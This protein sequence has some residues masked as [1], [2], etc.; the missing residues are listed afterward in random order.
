MAPLREMPQP[1][2][3]L[4]RAARPL[5][6]NADRCPDLTSDPDVTSGPEVAP[7]ADMPLDTDL[8]VSEDRYFEAGGRTVALTG[9]VL[10]YLPDLPTSAALVH[11]ID[12]SALVAD[13]LA[14]LVAVERAL[15]DLGITRSRLRLDAPPPQLA[16]ALSLLD[17]RAERGNGLIR[18]AAPLGTDVTLIQIRDAADWERKLELH[19]AV[20]REGAGE[21][22]AMVVAVERLK[23]EAGHLTLWLA[24]RDGVPAA[25]V[26]SAQVGSLLR[27]RDLTVAPTPRRRGVTAAVVAAMVRLAHIRGLDGAGLLAEPGSTLEMSCR[28]KGFTAA[29][30]VTTWDRALTPA[31]VERRAPGLSPFANQRLARKLSYAR[32]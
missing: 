30:T 22:P 9:A 11:R 18:A 16:I 3:R 5:M 7:R 13:P 20:E 31:A 25:A 2:A 28:S 19:S 6:S 24:L 14:W 12:P 10:T 4:Q 15:D 17:Y 1:P 23:Q 26:A 27:I 29:T 8:L 21:D 32:R